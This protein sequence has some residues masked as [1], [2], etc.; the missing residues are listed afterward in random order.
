MNLRMTRENDYEFTAIIVDENGDPY[1]LTGCDLTMTAKWNVKDSDANAVFTCTSDPADGITVADPTS[2][3]YTVLIASAK[4]TDC[5]LHR[6]FLP[7]DVQLVTATGQIKTVLR[8]NLRVDP[9]VT[10]P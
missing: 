5:P 3:Y 1:D 8:G 7:Y 6:V 9:N 10:N 2:G 4:T